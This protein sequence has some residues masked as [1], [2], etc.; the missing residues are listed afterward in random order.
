MKELEG[1]KD[2]NGGFGAQNN[3]FV[4]LIPSNSFLPNSNKKMLVGKFISR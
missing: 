4:S 1:I 2:A 3:A